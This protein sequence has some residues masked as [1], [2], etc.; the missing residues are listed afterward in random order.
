[1]SSKNLLK[2]FTLLWIVI[3]PSMQQ[4]HNSYLTGAPLHQVQPLRIRVPHHKIDE[5][6]EILNQHPN[7]IRQ[8]GHY[9]LNTYPSAHS[10]LNYRS[11]PG[12]KGL[13]SPVHQATAGIQ[14]SHKTTP[15][16]KYIY[17]IG[18]HKYVMTKR[19]LVPWRK[20]TE[21]LKK[22]V[23][24]I[25]KRPV[26]DYLKKTLRPED[27]LRSITKKINKKD[28]DTSKEREKVKKMNK[29][30]SGTSGKLEKVKKKNKKDNSSSDE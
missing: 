24:K 16:G 19:G 8:Y 4:N 21:N 29:K 1:M 26:S 6:K 15:K 10:P 14:I 30:D 27:M 18:G 7:I 13:L 23:K 9:L 20:R 25:L 2:Y 11:L 28:N 5:F 3:C 17:L 12:E 22:T